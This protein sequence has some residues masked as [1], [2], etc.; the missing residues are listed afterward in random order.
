MEALISDE[1]LWVDDKEQLKGIAV[2]FYSK[3]FSTETPVATEY[4]TSQFPLINDDL[5]YILEK[6][7][8]MQETK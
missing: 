5:R 8:T 6:D 3:L 7:V 4:I 2:N 1:G